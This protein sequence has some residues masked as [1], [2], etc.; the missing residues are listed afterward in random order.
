MRMPECPIH[1]CCRCLCSFWTCSRQRDWISEYWVMIDV[2][3]RVHTYSRNGKQRFLI[4]L[5]LSIVHPNLRSIIPVELRNSVRPFRPLHPFFPQALLPSIS[6]ASPPN[7]QSL[8]KHEGH[9]MPT[10]NLRRRSGHQISGQA[11]PTWSRVLAASCWPHTI[12]VF[13]VR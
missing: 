3:D 8:G 13:S 11:F 7:F 5:R 10:E 6:P 1:R 2:M 4:R 9:I 12:P